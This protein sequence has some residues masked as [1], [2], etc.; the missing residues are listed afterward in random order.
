M[1]LGQ[2]H[3]NIMHKSESLHS[4]ADFLCSHTKPN[5]TRNPR[6]KLFSPREKPP[7][8]RLKFEK[9]PSQIFRG[10]TVKLECD[11]EG[12][13][14]K[15]T[16]QCGDKQ[17]NSKDF[18][19][20]ITVELTQSCK[21]KACRGS[22]CSEWSNA[23]NLTVSDPIVTVKPQ[24][25]VFTGDTVTLICDVGWSTARTIYWFKD[26]KRIKAVSATVT[27]REVR[28]SDGGRYSC[29]VQNKTTQSQGVELT[30]RERP[31]PVVRVQPDGRVSRGQTVTLSCDIQQTDVINWSYS[32]NKDDS[33]IHVS[34]SQEYRISSVN[35]SHTGDYSC[36]GR[37]TGGSRYSHTSDKVTLTV[38][39]SEAPLLLLSAL[40]L[41]SFL[42]AASL[43]LL[44][45]IILGV[46]CYRAHAESNEIN[47]YTVT[48]ERV[49]SC[50]VFAQEVLSLLHMLISNI[51]TGNTQG[52]PKAAVILEHEPLTVR[53]EIPG[54]EDDWTYSWFIEGSSHPFSSDR[55]LSI[56]TG[57]SDTSSNVTCR[58][59]RRSDGQKSEISDAVTLTISHDPIVTVKPQSSVF[60]GDT[61][62]LICDVRRSTARTTYWF[63]DFKRIKADSETET[64]REVRVSDGGRYSCTVQNKTTQSQ[65]VMLTVRERPKPV[66]RVQPD[67]RVSRGQTVTL[68]CDIQQTDVINWSYSWN[69]DDSEIH[70]SQSQEYR[71][72]SV[73]ESHTGN[74]SCTGRE[75]GGSRY[76]HTSDK[77][78]LTVSGSE[79]PLL[80]LSALKLLSFLLA[81]SLY[82]LVSIILGVKCYRAHDESN[83]VNQYTVTK[84]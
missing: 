82:L 69:K 28:V 12:G 13:N 27:L 56:R 8:P 40:K 45:S 62:T 38:S 71:I 4:H 77:V 53:C 84:D 64:L 19:F 46:K 48:E 83:E 6:H 50:H 33:E 43:Y 9:K 49:S 60:T 63:K 21:C 80:L 32:W 11:N 70:V 17:H 47:Q 1:I 29:A 42:L 51:H 15:Y 54:P 22:F 7:K 14:W 39:G 68:S 26:F 78:T 16:L 25:S 72:S 58:G 44:V 31:K 67:G 35:E 55:E 79:A 36:T 2:T 18:D 10:D 5:R 20:L 23:V 52:K 73:N 34:Q 61:V 57:V 59:E 41:L 37:E 75:T 30:V 76:S 81:A 66:V 74:Y 3:I 65:G 24:S